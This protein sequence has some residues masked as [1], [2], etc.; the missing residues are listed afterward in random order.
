[1]Y[2]AMDFSSIPGLK[3]LGLDVK[4]RNFDPAFKSFSMKL[5]SRYT[6]YAEKKKVWG[7]WILRK[8]LEDDLP[9]DVAWRSKDPIK[10]RASMLKLFNDRILDSKF[11]KKGN[12]WSQI[13]LLSGTKNN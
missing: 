6:V 5:D 10:V 13:P 2:K 9:S 12:A 4:L 3:A 11:G 8:T 7:E 1:M